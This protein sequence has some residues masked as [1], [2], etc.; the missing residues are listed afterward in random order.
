MRAI[1]FCPLLA[2]INKIKTSAKKCFNTAM[3]KIR[4][5]IDF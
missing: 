3:L 1:C 2:L 4:L 5:H